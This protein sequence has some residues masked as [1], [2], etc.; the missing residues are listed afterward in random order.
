VFGND[1]A[2][3]A[4]AFDAALRQVGAFD[5]VVFAVLDRAADA[6]TYRAFERALGRL[7]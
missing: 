6:P 3:V 2:T 7:P 5:Q 4:G 1:P